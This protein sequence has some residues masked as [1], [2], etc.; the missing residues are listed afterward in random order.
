MDPAIWHSRMT[1]AR[2]MWHFA[3]SICT[4]QDKCRRGFIL[5]HPQSA[6]SW[7]DPLAVELMQRP[8]VVSSV[9]DQCRY[10][11]VAPGGQPMQKPTC[12]VS[13]M[14]EVSREF[15]NKR[16][17]CMVEHVQI[18]GSHH[19]QRLSTFAQRYP[20][21]LVQALCNCSAQFMGFDP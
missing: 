12:L 11:L 17:N 7:S 13:N 21:P 6:N 4:L 14:I 20:V 16:C 9:F 15:A 1:D 8:Q 3:L 5:E 10:G 18:Q 2:A 19:G